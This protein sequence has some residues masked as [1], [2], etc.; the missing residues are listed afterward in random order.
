MKILTPRVLRALERFNSAHPWDHNAHYHPWLLRQLP[1]RFDRA[2]DV[3]CGT[4]DLARLLAGRAN[5]VCGVDSDPEIVARARELTGDQYAHVTFSVADAPGGLPPGPY[6][7][8]TC[9]AVLHHLPLAESLA[10]FRQR[11]APGGT[12][13]VIGLAR[14]ETFVERLLGN[15]S[16]PLNA[17]TGWIK[18]GGRAAPRPVAMTAATQAAE[19]SL[20]E[21][22]REAGRIL[23]GARIRRRLFWRYTLVRRRDAG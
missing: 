7:V 2:M 1:R 3:G 4:G 13:V 22:V 21:I 16:V 12:L 23:P 17:V 15:L 18:N 14:E 11:L 20:A 8:I 10:C 19:A 9:V 5:R 6:D